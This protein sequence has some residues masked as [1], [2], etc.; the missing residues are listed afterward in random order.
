MEGKIEQTLTEHEIWSHNEV[1]RALTCEYE[2]IHKQ[3]TFLYCT[4]EVVV[5]VGNGHCAMSHSITTCSSGI[6]IL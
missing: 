1:T 3:K 4:S 2:I 6:R 5:V